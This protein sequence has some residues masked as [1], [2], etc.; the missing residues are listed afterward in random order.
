LIFI[1]SVFN[2][3]TRRKLHERQNSRSDIWNIIFQLDTNPGSSKEIPL[4]PLQI[5]KD[6]YPQLKDAIIITTPFKLLCTPAP[7]DAS[8]RNTWTA[9]ERVKAKKAKIA[10]DVAS[11]QEIVI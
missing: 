5:T 6:N 1:F 4:L 9:K 10:L 8:N 2:S 7:C 3:E 11:F